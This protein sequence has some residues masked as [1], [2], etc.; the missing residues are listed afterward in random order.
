M[1]E[2]IAAMK[3]RISQKRAE[4]NE[5][6]RPG[7]EVIFE[8]LELCLCRAQGNSCGGVTGHFTKGYKN[9]DIPTKGYQ[10]H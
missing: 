8:A 6:P 2:N 9:P 1:L 7:V 3:T 4:D 5:I 10:Y